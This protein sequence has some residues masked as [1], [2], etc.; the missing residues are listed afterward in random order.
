MNE[1]ELKTFSEEGKLRD[2]WS[3]ARRHALKEM[4]RKILQIN[5]KC[6]QK[7]TQI[8]KNKGSQPKW[9]ISE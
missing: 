8:I 6:Y 4:L 7:E 2:F 5:G 9:Y 1:E 3:A